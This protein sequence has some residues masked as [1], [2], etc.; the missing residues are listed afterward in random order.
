[1]KS[2][3][4]LLLVGLLMPIVLFAQK[5]VTTFLGIPVDGT[6]TE[7]RKKLSSKGFS[8]QGDYF[9]GE[10]N[11]RNVNVYIGTNNNKVWRIAVCDENTTDEANIK[12]RFNKLVKQF[13]KNKR[14]N[15][16]ENQTIPDAE[17]ISYEMTVHNKIYEAVFYQNPDTTKFDINAITREI[18]EEFSSKYSEEQLENPTEEIKNEMMSVAFQKTMEY[19]TKKHVWFRIEQ[20]YGKYYIALFYDNEYNN[21]DGEDL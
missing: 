17:D 2:K 3:L 20:L 15:G 7:M 4:T 19:A 11:G 6:K 12:V 10:F 14:Y 21:A 13:E 18:Y 16:L 8:S 9:T 1:M 5:D